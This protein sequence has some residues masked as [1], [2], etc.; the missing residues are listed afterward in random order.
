MKKL[1][2]FILTLVLLIGGLYT[3]ITFY[4]GYQLYEETMKDISIEETFE[5]YRSSPDYVTIDKL[6]NM[7]LQAVL[8]VE[9]HR[10][11]D[12]HGFDVIS[13]SKAVI[14]NII[15]KDYETGGSTI[16]QQLAKNLYF[17]FDKKMERKVAELIVARQIEDIFE[18]EEILEMYVNI[19]YFGD[20]FE[21]INQA[22]KGYFNKEPYELTEGESVLL[23]GIPQA[24]SSYA[25]FEHLD[26]A[27]SRSVRVLDAL[28]DKNYITSEQKKQIYE[29]ILTIKIQ[30]K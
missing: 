7:Y 30:V 5:T 9:D 21:G 26:L 28:V 17:S 22:S 24:P 18:K 8:A 10:F 27:V 12:H 6:P 2:I 20:S 1:I 19:I 29:N 23:A 13:F 25:L 14:K 3:G 11:F 4:K 16:T 15:A